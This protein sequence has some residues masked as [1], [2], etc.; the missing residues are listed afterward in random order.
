VSVAGDRIRARI[1]R[2]GSIPFD[3]YMAM[4]LYGD[5][6]FFTRGHGAGR[7][8][9]DFVT[10]PTVG[11]LFGRLVARALDD[12]WRAL[13]QPDPFVVIEGG[14][15]DGRLAADVLR[16]GPAC[17]PALRYVLVET[18][19]AL[20]ETQRE[21]LP[22]EPPDEALGPF[23][24]VDTHDGAPE[25]VPGL[26]PVVTH[27]DDLPALTVDGLVLANELLDNLPFGIVERTERGWSEIHVGFDALDDTLGEL[28]VPIDT[29]EALA[30]WMLADVAVGTRLPVPRVACDWI[31]RAARTIGRGPLILVDYFATTDELATRGQRSPGWLRTYHGHGRG[32]D[33]LVAPGELDITADVSLA[34]VEHAAA[35]A[36]VTIE[37]VMSQA[38]WL[39]TLGVEALVS[40]ADAVV[41]AQPSLREPQT[42]AA[43]SLR[44]EAAALTDPAGLGAHRVVRLRRTPQ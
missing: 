32:A 1:R 40:D 18:S 23:V 39:T 22:I 26:G 4:A 28:A 12:E 6:G 31:V 33:P 38:E 30:R 19:R 37:A 42:I 8:G 2:E 24:R 27:L 11:S 21:R 44:N 25:P 20:R 3:T 9:R 35:R 17:A 10:S 34:A 43:T 15:G 36:G 13:G 7:A 5:G 16:A 14:A 29:D 41:A